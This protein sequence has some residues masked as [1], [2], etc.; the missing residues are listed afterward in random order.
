MGCKGLHCDGCNHGSGGPAAAVITLLII[1]ALGVRAAWPAIVSAVEIAAW[2]VAGVSGAAL[3]ITAGVLT[4]RAVHRRRARRALAYRPAQ[5]FVVVIYE[6]Q[7]WFAGQFQAAGRPAPG[8]IEP[9]PDAPR[10]PV[11]GWR[12]GGEL[13]PRIGGDRDDRRPR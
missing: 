7:A 2:T 6:A 10:W 11:T 3:V 8:E 4:T 12:P 5:P 9:P 1:I 13:R